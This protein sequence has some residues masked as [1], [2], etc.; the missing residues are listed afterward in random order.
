MWALRQAGREV[1][2]E[3]R[4]A[5]PVL[6]DKNVASYAQ[7]R[8]RAK[9]GENVKDAYG[10][11]VPGLLR[12]SIRPSKNLKQIGP[13]TYQLKVGPRGQRVH[14]YAGKMEDKYGYMA[15]GYAAGEAAIEVASIQAFNRVWQK[16]GL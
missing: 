11:P 2:K 13:H 4:R 14:L 9:A 5:A 7:L 12:A 3:A 6:K 15:R 1:R 10:K 16:P 8:K